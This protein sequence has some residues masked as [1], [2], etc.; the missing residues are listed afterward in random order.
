MRAVFSRSSRGERERA[1]LQA[2]DQELQHRDDAE[3]EQARAAEQRLQEELRGARAQQRR[4]EE[5][6]R[7]EAAVLAEAESRLRSEAEARESHAADLEELECAVAEYQVERAILEEGSSSHEGQA[8]RQASEL[9]QEEQLKAEVTAVQQELLALAAQGRTLQ[10]QQHS[11]GGAL[12]LES[13]DDSSGDV[14]FDDEESSMPP[15]RLKG[16]ERRLVRL[17]DGLHM[18][19]GAAHAKMQTLEAAGSAMEEACVLA[20]RKLERSEDDVARL[21]SELTSLIREANDDPRGTSDAKDQEAAS[22]RDLWNLQA[23]RRATDERVQALLDSLHKAKHSPQVGGGPASLP[24][25]SPL[26]APRRRKTHPSHGG[27][28][29]HLVEHRRQGDRLSEDSFVLGVPALAREDRKADHAA[30]EAS[31]APP[32]G[33]AGDLADAVDQPHAETLSADVEPHSPRPASERS[34]SKLMQ[35]VSPASELVAENRHL[36]AE[37]ENLKQYVEHVR[38][39]QKIPAAGA[40][41]AQKSEP[42]MDVLSA[43]RVKLRSALRE[44]LQSSQEQLAEMQQA[45]ADAHRRLERERRAR[46]LCETRLAGAGIVM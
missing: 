36:R 11:R 34:H 41:Y 38:A 18:E 21:R 35:Q 7:T 16:R 23:E 26:L 24:A 44:Q 14:S 9:Q 27:S 40:P 19:I 30:L 42:C 28:K 2:H 6:Q 32:G 31:G 1:Q 12:G 37:A 17:Q 13:S 29:P 4:L 8:A 3:I 45:T 39:Q 15:K 20:R 43:T 5:D 22:I 25:A 46:Q 10:Q 33:D